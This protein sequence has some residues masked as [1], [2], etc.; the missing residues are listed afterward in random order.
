MRWVTD[1]I[2]ASLPPGVRLHRVPAAVED[3]EPTSLGY[4]LDLSTGDHLLVDL[5]V[6]L[7][8]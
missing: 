2:E 5:W 7:V 8:V 1:V 6:G 4:R 3:L